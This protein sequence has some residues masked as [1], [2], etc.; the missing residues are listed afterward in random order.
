MPDVGKCQ[1]S[2]PPPNDVHLG[3]IIRHSARLCETPS[4]GQLSP[5]FLDCR[6]PHPWQTKLKE[7]ASM[8]ASLYERDLA[9][10]A[11]I[12]KVRFFPLAVTGGRGS[13]LIDESGRELLDLSATWGAASLGYGH[14][15]V[16][17]A[18]TRAVAN[19]AGSEHPLQ[20]ERA[21]RRAGR[22]AAGDHPGPPWTV[23]SAG[24]GSAIR[25]PTPT[26]RWCAPSPW[27]RAGRASSPSSAPIT[28]ASPARP[29]SPAIRATATA[30]AAP[31]WCRSPI[32]IPTGRKW[33]A[34]S[35]S[36]CSPTWTIFSTP[37]ARRKA[38][39]PSSSSR[40]SPTAG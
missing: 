30:R 40:S 17:E 6:E 9:V 12:E 18:A 27:R 25:A 35:A 8:A 20:R 4:V 32:P 33:P 19:P 38:S 23:A 31:A 2:A 29:R 10:I 22:R 3:T 26:T 15:A 21:G 1:R 5:A 36:P 13:Y 28:A 34:T 39:A 11:G 37:S 24:S 7:G 14:P 16:V